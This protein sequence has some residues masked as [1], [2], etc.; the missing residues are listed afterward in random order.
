MNTVLETDRYCAAKSSK[1]Y[2]QCTGIAVR[3]SAFGCRLCCLLT[4][5]GSWVP[6]LAFLSLNIATYNMRWVMA[7]TPAVTWKKWVVSGYMSSTLK[8]WSKCCAGKIY[9]YAAQDNV[10]MSRGS[11]SL[12]NHNYFPFFQILFPQAIS[13]ASLLSVLLN[14]GHSC[15]PGMAFTANK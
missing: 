8:P 12:N 15:G 6:H 2:D 3:N 4:M 13:V 11:L 1:M 10:T 7:S 9:V 14:L 5:G